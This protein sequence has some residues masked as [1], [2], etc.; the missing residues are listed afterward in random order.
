M[1]REENFIL[2]LAFTK[3]YEIY[4]FSFVLMSGPP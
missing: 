1:A 2:N 4:G 3:K